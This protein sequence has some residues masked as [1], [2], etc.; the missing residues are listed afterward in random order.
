MTVNDIGDEG[1]KTLSEKL[2]SNTA[3]TELNLKRVKRKGK[4]KKRKER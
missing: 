2:K 3:L 1:A 4:R